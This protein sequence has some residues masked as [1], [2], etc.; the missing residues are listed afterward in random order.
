VIHYDEADI[1]PLN[2]VFH[3]TPRTES[4]RDME[5]FIE[6]H[7]GLSI[8][9]KRAIRELLEYLATEHGRDFLSIEP[10]TALARHWSQF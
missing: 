5:Y 7:D 4:G 9:Q 3:L 8:D 2:I 1:V 10:A 6:R